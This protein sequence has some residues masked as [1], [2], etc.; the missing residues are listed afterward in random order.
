MPRTNLGAD[1]YKNSDLTELIRLHKAKLNLSNDEVGKKIGV[2]GK[3]FS[4]F[5]KQPTITGD[6]KPRAQAAGILWPS[7][8]L[9]HV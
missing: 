7:Q 8:L 9:M 4:K 6:F 5:L 3:T 1:A 2:S